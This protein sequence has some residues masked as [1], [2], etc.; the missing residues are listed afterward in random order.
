M[1]I[2]VKGKY[3]KKSLSDN[4]SQYLSLLALCSLA[5]FHIICLDKI[6]GTR[7]TCCFKPL[8]PIVVTV[9]YV[10]LEIAMNEFENVVNHEYIRSY[11]TEDEGSLMYFYAI[12]L[13][14]ENYKS[15]GHGSIILALI[16]ILHL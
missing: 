14:Q 11:V 13:Q 5:F 10:R 4:F 9:S 15:Q 12:K 1:R 2:I 3:E 7:K 6:K 8:K 16:F